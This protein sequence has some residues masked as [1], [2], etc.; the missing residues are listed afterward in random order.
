LVAHLV[1]L[2]ASAG[3]S[4][5]AHAKILN[6]DHHFQVLAEAVASGDS[7]DAALQGNSIKLGGGKKTVGK[8]SP[9][10]NSNCKHC[11][12]L[13]LFT[14]HRKQAVGSETPMHG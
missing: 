14:A 11:H 7:L 3:C 4:W 10:P 1:Q 5:H 12:W 6:L 2:A 8:R 13:F 9:C